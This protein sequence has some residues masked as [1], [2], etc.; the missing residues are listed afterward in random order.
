[1]IA[2]SRSVC[3]SGAAP[4]APGSALQRV[5]LGQ[6]ASEAGV[7]L[8]RLLDAQMS[9]LDLG[10]EVEAPVARALR[11]VR[12]ERLRPDVELLEV[13]VGPCH[14]LRQERVGTEVGVEVRPEPLLVVVVEVGLEP[15]HR[16]GER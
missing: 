8:G 4:P 16:A 15:L 3:G 5:V 1:M 2:E 10:P 14:D 13:V 12:L 9:Q 11:K 7:D 6:R